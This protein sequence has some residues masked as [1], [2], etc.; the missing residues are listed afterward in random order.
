MDLCDEYLTNQ[1]FKK[2]Y[3]GGGNK[4]I[5]RLFVTSLLNAQMVDFNSKPAQTIVDSRIILQLS[6]WL[7]EFVSFFKN[8]NEEE[9]REHRDTEHNSTIKKDTRLHYPMESFALTI[10]VEALRKEGKYT[11]IYALG[12]S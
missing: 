12:A 2:W 8:K 6:Y 4:T 11:F 7:E 1:N 9:G 5:L 10:A 3:D